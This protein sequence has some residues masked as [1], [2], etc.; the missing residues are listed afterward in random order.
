MTAA[1]VLYSATRAYGILRA[2]GQLRG[3]AA[4]DA[5]DVVV[6]AGD[7]VEIF[8]LRQ[9]KLVGAEFRIAQ[10]V[11]ED[12]EDV[13]EIGLQAGQGNGGGIGV[14]VG[15]DFGGADF[16]IVIQL[17]A[18]LR[19]GAAGAPDFA[20]DVEQAGLGRGLGAGAAAN[21]GDA[22]DQRQFVVLLQEDDH[23]V[24]QDDAFGLL[25]MKGGKRR[26]I[27]LLPVGGLGGRR[28]GLKDEASHEREG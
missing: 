19:L 21:A 1:T 25:G 24:G 18:G 8:L 12:L 15:L 20:V 3:L 22:V 16:E 13:V 23:A 11:V 17:I 2:V 5:I 6:A 7:G 10:Q 28:S 9:V 14:A 26:N 4:G 27:D